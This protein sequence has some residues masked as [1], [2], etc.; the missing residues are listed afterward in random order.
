MKIVKWNFSLRRFSAFHFH[1]RNDKWHNFRE[2]FSDFLLIKFLSKGSENKLNFT[3]QNRHYLN[4]PEACVCRGQ[5]LNNGCSG[6]RRQ[7]ER[8]N[9]SWQVEECSIIR[10]ILLVFCFSFRLSPELSIME[11]NWMS[12]HRV[13]TSLQHFYVVA[14]WLRWRQK[15]ETASKEIFTM[16]NFRRN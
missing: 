14:R 12:L 15:I 8:G 2:L 7:M 9:W 4:A 6:G 1:R 5:Q 10:N 3:C 16:S 13:K 11:L